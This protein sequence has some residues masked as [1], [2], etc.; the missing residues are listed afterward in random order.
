LVEAATP[1]V[2]PSLTTFSLASQALGPGSRRSALAVGVS[3]P[4]PAHNLPALP[5]ADAEASTVASLYGQHQVIVGQSVTKA[6]VLDQMLA[7]SVIHFAGHALLNPLFPLQSQLVLRDGEAISAGEIASLKL[8]RGTIAVLGACDTALGR[9][10]NGEGP[11]SLVRSF[12]A[13]GASSVVAALWP[14]QDDDAARLLK[15]L[16]Q[17]LAAGETLASSLAAAQRELIQA[18]HR[19]SAWAGFTVI[20]GSDQERM[21]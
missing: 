10:F 1:I 6:V 3:A 17:R 5:N 8:Q 13:A 7:H 4:A 11:I 21:R 9:T 15:P 16:H 18:G 2:A 14:V 19:T 20:G 12:L